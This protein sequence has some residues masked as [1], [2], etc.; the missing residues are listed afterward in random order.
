[1]HACGRHEVQPPAAL[2]KRVKGGM[3]KVAKLS[4]GGPKRR[5]LISPKGT[6]QVGSKTGHPD[7]RF[8]SA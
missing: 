1:M 2:E 8:V 4:G 7:I 6:R 3:D 5:E